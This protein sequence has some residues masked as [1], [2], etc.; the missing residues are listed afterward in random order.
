VAAERRALRDGVVD[1]HERHEDQTGDR[2][3]RAGPP[4]A[5]Q[6]R[7]V[8]DDGGDE[9]DPDQHGPQRDRALLARGDEPAVLAQL[10][11]RERAD[12]DEAEQQGRVVHLRECRAPLGQVAGAEHAQLVGH[13][14]ADRLAHPD[15]QAAEDHHAR[16]GRDEPGDADLREPEPV[17]HADQHT[18]GEAEE[19][20]DPPR[21]PPVPGR[22][23]HHHPDEAG[24]R[25]DGQVDL[26]DHDDHDHPDREDEDVGVPREE[27][28]EVG[29]GE[30]ASAGR[31]V[32]P[33]EQGDEREHH[34][35]LAVVAAEDQLELRHRGF[36]LWAVSA[37]AP[38]TWWSSSA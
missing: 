36:S 37:R 16:E 5:E 22:Q 29:R 10:A 35:E 2:E 23:R 3:R 9:H 14:D 15:Q 19:G 21:Q 13:R 11:P 8:R 20:S 30:H 25:P 18:D 6:P 24:D 12:A 34:R 26:A 31:D 32:E 17:P 27:V 28:L 33:D 1:D 4:A 38:R 7:D